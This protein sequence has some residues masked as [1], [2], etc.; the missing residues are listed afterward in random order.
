M[1]TQEKGEWAARQIKSNNR[2]RQSFVGFSETK[3]F[4]YIFENSANISL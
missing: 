4:Y 1:L 2:F 3:I